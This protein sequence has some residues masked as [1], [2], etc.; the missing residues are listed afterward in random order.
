MFLCW[1]CAYSE[2]NTGN[3]IY[4]EVIWLETWS[5]NPYYCHCH[6]CKTEDADKGSLVWSVEGALW[7][8]TNSC[9]CVCFGFILQNLLLQL[10]MMPTQRLFLLNRQLGD[11]I[12]VVT[13]SLH[14][15]PWSKGTASEPWLPSSLDL[16][17][18]SFTKGTGRKTSGWSW[19]GC[20]FLM[21]WFYLRSV[22]A[23]L[24]CQ[25]S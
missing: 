3:G 10:D 6:L 11:R 9:V 21:I 18:H 25:P 15:F 20:W 16:L 8:F 13:P 14:Q 23:A 22:A 7:G 19:E 1:I 4:S 12:S 5:P 17:R 24:S 2:I